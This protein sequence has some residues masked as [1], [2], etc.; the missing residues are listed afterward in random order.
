MYSANTIFL[1]VFRCFHVAHQPYSLSWRWRPC[2]ASIL[3]QYFGSRIHTRFERIQASFSDIS[4][5]RRKTTR[6]A[7]GAGFAREESEI[8]LFERLNTST[9]AALCVS[10][11]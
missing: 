11:N 6:R 7:P 4:R 5:R 1:S 3:V 9:L 10:C 2:P 8:S